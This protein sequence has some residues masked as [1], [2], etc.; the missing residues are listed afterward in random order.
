M[1]YTKTD[2]RPD[3]KKKKGSNFLKMYLKFFFKITMINFK[4]SSEVS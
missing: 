2:V 1:S 4:C 3:L